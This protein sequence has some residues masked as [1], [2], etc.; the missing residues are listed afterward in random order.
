MAKPQPIESLD[1]QGH[2]Y[3]VGDTIHLLRNDEGFEI[4]RLERSVTARVH[5]RGKF[6]DRI[7]VKRRDS[8]KLYIYEIGRESTWVGQIPPW[9]KVAS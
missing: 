4:V 5:I 8:E 7:Y 9:R 6:T 3:K 2:K 1:Y